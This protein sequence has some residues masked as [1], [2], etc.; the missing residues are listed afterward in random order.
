MTGV[1]ALP[2]D[3]IVKES[4]EQ[5]PIAEPIREIERRFQLDL[6]KLANVNK[7]SFWSEIQVFFRNLMSVELSPVLVVTTVAQV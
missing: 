4:V 7:Q 3:E 2:G 1:A 6:E 5:S